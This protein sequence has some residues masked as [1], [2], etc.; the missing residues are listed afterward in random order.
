MS[1]YN[2]ILKRGVAIF[3]IA[4]F[5][6]VFLATCA[7][8]CPSAGDLVRGLFDISEGYDANTL[9]NGTIE[10]REDEVEIRYLDDEGRSWTVLYDI[11]GEY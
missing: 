11:V 6:M 10:I 2:R 3:S 7:P 5:F 1:H 4:C 8:D 9:E